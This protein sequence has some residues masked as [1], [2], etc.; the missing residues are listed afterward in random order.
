MEDSRPQLPP[1]PSHRPRF[2]HTPL[3]HPLPSHTTS[4]GNYNYPLGPSPLLPNN[5]NYRHSSHWKSDLNPYW[6]PLLWS[7][8]GALLVILV[9]IISLIPWNVISNIVIWAINKSRSHSL[10]KNNIQNGKNNEVFGTLIA[11][12]VL[13]LRFEKGSLR[14]HSGI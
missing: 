14:L 11:H 8:Q 4:P 13:F 12:I 1:S 6:C 10:R 5:I 9:W 2:N 3:Y 7:P